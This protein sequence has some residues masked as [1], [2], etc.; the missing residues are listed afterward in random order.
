LFIGRKCMKDA[1]KELG[2]T[3]VIDGVVVKLDRSAV[4]SSVCG[5]KRVGGISVPVAE[6]LFRPHT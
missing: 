4:A 6:C 2:S 5:V 3:T 1:C